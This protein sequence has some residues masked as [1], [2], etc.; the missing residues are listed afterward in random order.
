MAEGTRIRNLDE[1]LGAQEVKWGE[2]SEELTRTRG[3]HNQKL[4]DM[5]LRM[6]KVDSSLGELKQLILGLQMASKEDANST[7]VDSRLIENG[8]ANSHLH[9]TRSEPLF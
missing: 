3:E 1:Q 4:V 2:I 6:E 9:S 7:K 8:D 5:E